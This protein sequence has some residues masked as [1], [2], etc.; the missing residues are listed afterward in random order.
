MSDYI[1]RADVIKELERYSTINGS[2]IGYHSGAV[3]CAIQAV[4]SLQAADVV[5]VVRCKDCRYR[6]T[7]DC[8]MYIVCGS[9]G[10]QWEWTTDDGFC[11]YGAPIYRR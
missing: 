10:G 2:S 1:K 8:A 11:S 4:E 7:D 9:C 5:E 6:Y 3:D